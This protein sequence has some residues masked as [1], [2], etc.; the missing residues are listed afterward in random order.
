MICDGRGV[1]GLGT[2]RPA[3]KA[4][5]GDA[6]STATLA[7]SSSI[8]TSVHDPTLRTDRGKAT[9]HRLLRVVDDGASATD[10]GRRI[11]RPKRMARP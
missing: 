10:S 4:L 5:G 1:R 8:V 11:A 9:S 3:A 7:V 6:A 2:D